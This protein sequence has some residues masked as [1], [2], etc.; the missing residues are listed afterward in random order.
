MSHLHYGQKYST[1]ATCVGKLLSMIMKI[2]SKKAD[3]YFV[4]HHPNL[5]GG[6]LFALVHEKHSARTGVSKPSPSELLDL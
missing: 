3:Y 4:N 2:G 5:E 6:V 1:T